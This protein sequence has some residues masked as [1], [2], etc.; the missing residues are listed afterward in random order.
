MSETDK[1]RNAYDALAD[2]YAT[3]YSDSQQTHF[4]YNRDLVL[5]RLLDI[6]GSVHNLTILDAGCGEGI[7]SRSFGNANRIVG[8]DLSPRLIRYASER[9]TTKQIDYLVHD[10]SLPLPQY[11]HTFDLAVSNLVLN[12]VPDYI[13]FLTT[14]HDVLKPNGRFVLSM[15]NPYSAVVRQKVDN[16]FDSAAIAEYGFGAVYYYHRT[17]EAYVTAFRHA[18]FMIQGLYD[19]HMSEEMVARL[20]EKNRH[21]PWYSLYHRFPFI[22]I[23]DLLRVSGIEEN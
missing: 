11:R 1:Q 13:G 14:I 15:N 18:G 8:I 4:N 20:P 2:A 3:A 6:V 12:D 7:V 10:L 5:P 16:Y 9:D 21:F 23:L 22:I 17:M 19:L